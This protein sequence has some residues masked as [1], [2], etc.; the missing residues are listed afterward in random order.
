MMC[1][2]WRVDI[3]TGFQMLANYIVTGDKDNTI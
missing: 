2:H 1:K 3:K